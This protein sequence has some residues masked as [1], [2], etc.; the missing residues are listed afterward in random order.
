MRKLGGSYVCCIEWA[1]VSRVRTGVPAHLP[2]HSTLDGWP[3]ASHA[4]VR[5]PGDTT[6]F[7]LKHQVRGYELRGVVTVCCR[8]TALSGFLPMSED[9]RMLSL[10]NCSS[11][12]IRP[13]VSEPKCAL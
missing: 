3:C 11:K 1:M 5:P 6:A 12:N 13:L 2:V 7:R 10:P 8:L 9:R 4:S